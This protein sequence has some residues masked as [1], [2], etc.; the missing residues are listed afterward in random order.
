MKKSF[1]ALLGIGI[2]LAIYLLAVYAVP[3][4]GFL[5]RLVEANDWLSNGEISQVTF[6]ILSLT[7]IFGLAR[8]DT[9]TF[10]LQGVKARQLVRPVVMGVAVSV[11]F[12]LLGAMMVMI[13]GPPGQE[14]GGAMSGK[15]LLNFVL[16]VVVL[17]SICEEVFSRGLIQGFLAPLKGDGIRL[18]GVLI[19]WPVTICALLFGLG[20]LCLLSSLG[21]S[22]V[23]MIVIS[24]TVL[25]FIAGYY[26]ER[27]DS[28]IPAIAV[29]M[30]FNIVSGIIPRLLMMAASG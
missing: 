8:G 14:G 26:R 7:L 3:S 18:S 21:G 9:S 28:I 17:A 19:S 24:A 16:T 11:L 2:W 4:I 23:L 6:L 29:H 5:H 12:F 20:H 15:S 13:S 10:G 27:T 30:T 22:M 25:G 1:T